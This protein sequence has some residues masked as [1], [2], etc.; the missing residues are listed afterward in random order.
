MIAEMKSETYSCSERLML[1]S[2]L[3]K[4][5][6]KPGRSPSEHELLLSRARDIVRAVD[7]DLAR[8]IIKSA[9]GA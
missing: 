7:K 8:E 1:A 2:H 9:T 5:A 6:Y 4:D 3:I